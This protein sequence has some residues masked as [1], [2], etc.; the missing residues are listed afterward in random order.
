VQKEN[1]GLVNGKASIFIA[2]ESSQSTFPYITSLNPCNN[3]VKQEEKKP[4]LS[5]FF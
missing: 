3:P 5:P 2:L 4:L 1:M